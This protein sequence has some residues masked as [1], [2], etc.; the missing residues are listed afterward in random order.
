MFFQHLM[1]DPKKLVISTKI[2]SVIGLTCQ[3]DKMS[4]L[5]QNV[6]KKRERMGDLLEKTEVTRCPNIYRN[7]QG[8]RTKQMRTFT[9]TM[10]NK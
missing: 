1:A 2:A 6:P 5:W 10:M 3:A 4:G 7:Q 8:D 9:D